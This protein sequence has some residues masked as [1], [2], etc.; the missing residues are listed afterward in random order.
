MVKRDNVERGERGR[1]AT[2]DRKSEGEGAGAV[3]GE[4]DHGR[5]RGNEGERESEGGEGGG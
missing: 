2:S 4:R 5:K 3:L 1:E